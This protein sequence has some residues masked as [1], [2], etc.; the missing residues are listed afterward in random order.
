MKQLQVKIKRHKIIFVIEQVYILKL[1]VSFV[2][3]KGT[4][5]GLKSSK[6]RWFYFVFLIWPYDVG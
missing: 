1:S 3:F 5:P 6:N 4:T 2:A